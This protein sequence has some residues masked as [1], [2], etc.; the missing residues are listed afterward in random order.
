MASKLRD[1]R[2]NNVSS[3]A[4]VIAHAAAKPVHDD[5]RVT[6]RVS[7]GAPEN[8]GLFRVAG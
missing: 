1:G 3:F 6:D 4:A 5:G 8:N 2:A 7:V